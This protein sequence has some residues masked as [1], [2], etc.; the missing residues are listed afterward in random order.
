MTI[1]IYSPV[2][3]G[4]ILRK[5]EE[6]IDIRPDQQYRQVTIKM[7]GQGVVL[8]NEVAG[9]EIAAARR[10]VVRPQQFILSR[11]DARNGALGIVPP[12]LDGAV[13]SNDFPTFN[14]DTSCVLPEYLGWMSKTHDFVELCKAASEG[15]TNRVRLQEDRFLAL[16]IPLPS[17]TE[18]R[19]IVARIEELAAKIAEAR[20]LRREAVEEA[21]A[22]RGGSQRF[23]ATEKGSFLLGSVATIIDPN[24]SHRYPIYVDEGIPIIS[25]SD[26]VG[27]DSVSLANAKKVPLSFYEETLGRFGVG[28]G[29]IIFSRKGK[30]GYARL[31]PV[32]V[33]LAM[34]H[35]LC[36]IQPDRN[37]LLPEY[38]LH[39]TRNRAFIG[40]LTGTMNPNVGVPT[41]GLEV[42]RKAPLPL[43]TIDYQRRII[44]YLDSLQAKVDALKALQAETAAELDAL[45]PA[46]LD[47]AFKGDL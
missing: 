32:G 11:I 34:T 9:A 7:W 12:S 22:L 41:L 3:L 6:W 45:L 27:E 30:V 5:S 14:L 17:L 1:S 21:E 42:I 8:R 29:D 35:T 39:Y 2:K 15:T 44:A 19:R 37:R 28:E 33:K 18:Q 31:H 40:Y 26:F 46:V 47:K 20:G 25:S 43:P 10:F 23:F 36:V 4:E 38:L 13:V 16:Q 24:P